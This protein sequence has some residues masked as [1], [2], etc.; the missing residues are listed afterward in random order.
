MDARAAENPDWIASNLAAPRATT[1]G[2]KNMTEQTKLIHIQYKLG[3]LRSRLQACRTA[4]V[5][6]LVLKCLLYSIISSYI[7]IN[8]VLLD[9]TS[10]IYIIQLIYFRQFMSKL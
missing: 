8:R 4:K 9:S 6:N 5:Y 3:A 1:T 7:K 2:V 10:I